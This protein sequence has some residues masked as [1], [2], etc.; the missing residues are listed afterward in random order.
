MRL[1]PYGICLPC[2]Y[3]HTRDGDTVEVRVRNGGLTWAVR[4]I[5]CWVTDNRKSPIWEKARRFA[6]RECQEASDEGRLSLFVPIAKLPENLLRGITFDRIAGHLYVSTD[7][8]LSELLVREG[9]A[10]EHK[11]GEPE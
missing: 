7:T 9:L 10:G 1:P 6:E 3:V 2:H 11:G 8:T 4:L 5:D